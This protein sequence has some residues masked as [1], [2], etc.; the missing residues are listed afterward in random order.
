MKVAVTGAMGFLG[1]HVCCRLRAV[2]GVEPLRIGRAELADQMLLHD[3]LSRADIV[4]HLAGVNR[5]D[6][7]AEVEDGNVEIADRLAAAVCRLRHRMTIV[8]ANSIQSGTDTA[9]GRGKR[10]AAAVLATVCKASR[11]RFVDVRLP[12]LFGEHGLPHYNSFVATF[13]AEVAADRRPS[14]TNDR[15]IPLLHVQDAAAALIR[16]GEQTELGELRPRGEPV[17]VSWVADTLARLHDRYRTGEMAELSSRLT[18]NLFNT[19]R[20]FR[21]P[22]MF[23]VAPDLHADERGVLTEI[24]RAHGGTSQSFVSTTRAG[25]TR[26]DHYHLHKVERFFVL[27]GS[28]RINLRRLLHDEVVSF[29]LSGDTP[30]YVDM[31]T[32]WVHNIE[33]VGDDEL[34]TVFWSDQ[35]LDPTNPDQ[36]PERVMQR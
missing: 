24:V 23:P 29:H 17:L 28:A 11:V 1:W 25:Q 32:L 12:N 2:H 16:A 9:Y 3:A 19:Y 30:A 20:A 34:V 4:L 31:P 26:G 21:F 36:Y 18:V 6:S 35:L 13:A 22:D 10:K 15:E 8:N 7:D 27:K 5:A 33:N 14:V